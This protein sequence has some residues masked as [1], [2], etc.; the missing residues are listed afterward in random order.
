[1][2]RNIKLHGIVTKYINILK[3]ISLK[4]E[5]KYNFNL[6]KQPNIKINQLNNDEVIYNFNEKFNKYI[7]N[8]ILY[9]K[10]ENPNINLDLLFENLK[11][12]T[13]KE[14]F[15]FN[16]FILFKSIIKA[17]YD[18]KENT[19]YLLKDNY[20]NSIYHELLHCATKTTHNEITL[21]GF[22]QSRNGIEIG[23]GINEGYTA[24]LEKRYFNVKSK[25]EMEK[26]IASL[27][28]KIIGKE[29]MENLYFNADLDNVIEELKKFI[30][31]EDAIIFITY[32]DEI[33]NKLKFSKPIEDVNK[34]ISF[35][36]KFLISCY[37]KKIYK[38]YVDNLISFDDFKRENSNFI[39]LLCIDYLTKNNKYTFLTPEE[40]NEFVKNLVDETLERENKKK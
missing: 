1:M 27:L 37:S 15:N 26:Y 5:N 7:D 13:I 18:P 40:A 16:K 29:K 35:I 22:S 11:T 8:F 9:I 20:I 17:S 23:R 30:S 6:S 28:E 12:L 14:K 39:N 33:S 2:I 19:I 34:K 3:T 21:V 38:L 32:L 4:K 36:S 25:Y 10:K 31:E 24:L